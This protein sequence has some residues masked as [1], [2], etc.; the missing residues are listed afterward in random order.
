MDKSMYL[1]VHIE[2]NDIRFSKIH[3]W[4]VLLACETSILPFRKFE[5]HTKSK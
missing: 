4:F 3:Q 1:F 5:S 2:S